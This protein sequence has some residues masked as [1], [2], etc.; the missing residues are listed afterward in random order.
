MKWQRLSKE[1]IECLK[2]GNYK[3][4]ADY[5]NSE[6]PFD[7]I[8]FLDLSDLG[9]SDEE[10]KAHWHSMLHGGTYSYSDEEVLDLFSHFCLLTSPTYLKIVKQTFARDLKK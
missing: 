6:F 3:L 4:V 9:Y 10:M 7:L 1:S 5:L 2:D 8:K